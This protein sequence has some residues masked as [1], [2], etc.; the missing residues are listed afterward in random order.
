METYAG[1]AEHTD[2]QVARLVAA[3]EELGVL[4][5]TLLFYNLGDN[6][7]SAEGGLAGSFNWVSAM[8]GVPQTAADILPHL[9]EIGSPKAYNHYPVGWAHAMDAP[10]KW[11]K[12]IASHWG[13]TRNGMI[14]HWPG[15]SS[16]PVLSLHRHRADHSRSGQAAASR[17][18]QPHSAT[19]HRRNELPLHVRRREGRRAA[20][21]AIFRAPRQSRPLSPRMD[22]LRHAFHSLGRHRQVAS[23]R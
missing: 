6:G 23:V 16:Q 12:Q 7:A 2:A 1:H 8:N 13:G 4:D 22:G 19:S 17:V 14:V 15:R 20:H 21:H 10:Y 5:S 9:D 11:T 3:L 18:R